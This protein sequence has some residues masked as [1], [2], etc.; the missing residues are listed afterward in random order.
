MLTISV[1]PNLSLIN[2]FYNILIDMYNNNL[3]I[4]ALNVKVEYIKKY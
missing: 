4:Q 3:K 1:P 2:G